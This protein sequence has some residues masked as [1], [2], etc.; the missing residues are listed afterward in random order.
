MDASVSWISLKAWI[1]HFLE[2]YFISSSISGKKLNCFLVVSLCLVLLSSSV[3][4]SSWKDEHP[5]LSCSTLGKGSQDGIPL[6]EQVSFSPGLLERGLQL[7]AAAEHE[8]FLPMERLLPA[9]L[10]CT[11]KLEGGPV[12]LLEGPKCPYWQAAAHTSSGVR[13]DL[14]HSVLYPFQCTSSSSLRAA[15]DILLGHPG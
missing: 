11:T 9:L 8:A 4:P 14:T 10:L 13:E 5:C 6:S 7:G 3:C 1:R 15:T 12:P 2:L